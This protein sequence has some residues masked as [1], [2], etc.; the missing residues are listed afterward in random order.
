MVFQLAVSQT[1]IAWLMVTSF[2]PTAENSTN[3]IPNEEMNEFGP[4]AKPCS[5]RPVATSKIFTVLLLPETAS[6]LPSGLKAKTGER[7]DVFCP[8]VDKS[9]SSRPVA[10]S[11]SL[12]VFERNVAIAHSRPSG[13]RE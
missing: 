13:D 5:S 7:L 3:I 4:P 6:S 12:I 11:Q 10:V 9:R 2:L 8:P 1:R